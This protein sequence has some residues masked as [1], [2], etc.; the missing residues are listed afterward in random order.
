MNPNIHG[1]L[2]KM[3]TSVLDPLVQQPRR[4]NSYKWLGTLLLP[5]NLV[6]LIIIFLS[7][8]KFKVTK[9]PENEPTPKMISRN[10]SF[11]TELSKFPISDAIH[12]IEAKNDK[13]VD[14]YVVRFLDQLLPFAVKEPTVEINETCKRPA[15][16]VSDCESYPTIFEGTREKRAKLA[17]AFK[18]GFEADVL[19]IVLN[20]YY[21]LVDKIFLFE[22][23]RTHLRRNEKP[24]VWEHLKNQKRFQKFRNMIVHLV[25]DDAPFSDDNYN[26]IWAFERYQDNQLF[27]RVSE[28]NKG[29]KYFEESD[30]ILIG[31]LDEVPSLNVL[32]TIKSCNFARN[33]NTIYTGIWFP[34]GNINYAF[35]PDWPAKDAKTDKILDYSLNAPSFWTW[36][37]A[38]DH[39]SSHDEGPRRI[40]GE[41]LPALL[42]GMHM[43]QYNYIPYFMTKLASSS[44][45]N[46]DNFKEA[47]EYLIEAIQ[48]NNITRLEFELPNPLRWH[49][50]RIVNISEV[51][52]NQTDVISMPWFLSCNIDRYPNW[53]GITDPRLK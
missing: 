33:T 41:K 19:E 5:L 42:G 34:F 43:T 25:A 32:N 46:I 22:A 2:T 38:S 20:Q 44:E 50:N 36:K 9:A 7:R 26:N 39:S 30:V 47:L 29:T 51:P 40:A 1:K 18:F 24:L 35:R 10:G 49:A 13:L 16:P 3:K 15:I 17:A 48:T 31:D 4:S 11:L 28:W 14:T 45:K 6:V 37:S 52:N 27:S 23:T 53:N 21:G 8:E 12:A